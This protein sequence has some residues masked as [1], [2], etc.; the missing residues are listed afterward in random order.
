MSRSLSQ[1]G[2]LRV[3]PESAIYAVNTPSLTP[4]AN[5]QNGQVWLSSRWQ[6]S[7]IPAGAAQHNHIVQP[8]GGWEG[9]WVQEPQVWYNTA[10]SQF[11]MIYTGGVASEYLGLMTCP[12][13]S[14]PM[15]LGN[16]TRSGPN[17]VIGNTYGGWAGSAQHSGV[18]V[19][20]G[21]IY[22]YF[23]DP[24]TGA[25]HVATAATSA[26]SVF[27]HVGIVFTPP[28]GTIAP[29]ANPHVMNV[30]GT[31]TMFFEV[32]DS[33]G[34]RWQLGRATSATPTGTFT[35]VSYPM[36]GLE[37][38][39]GKSCFSNIF[40][41]KEG[42]LYVAWLHC[43][44]GQFQT[45]MYLPSAVYRATS[46][47]LNTWTLTDGQMPLIRLDH[48]FEVDQVADVCLVTGPTGI[49]Y[50]FWSACDNV[51]STGH[52]MGAV[53]APRPMQWDGAKWKPLV[54]ATPAGPNLLIPFH[55]ANQL[56]STLTTTTANGTA[57]AVGIGFG[58][59]TL[60]D[61]SSLTASAALRV[62]TDTAGKVMVKVS[63]LDQ[64]STVKASSSFAVDDMPVNTYR[65]FAPPT[66][67][68]NM[69]SGRTYSVKV[70][71][72][73]YAATA[74]TTV[75]ASDG[76]QLVLTGTPARL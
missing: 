73:N 51:F 5:P 62:K 53:V 69:T 75:E 72:T 36:P 32:R 38:N 1:Q 67:Q 2:S 64:F 58:T 6:D 28:A 3:P 41:V 19:E 52:I 14:D 11:C 31:Y 55:G 13:T 45:T 15:V 70:E 22:V 30:A 34:N 74:T 17:P 25:L 66:I 33:T 49:N 59:V 60:P 27:T 7:Y 46:T 21:T 56:G 54:S 20:N 65:S 43:T 9:A 24:A 47:D 50:A 71:V 63:I 37:I 44:W 57:V 12:G 61:A 29:S 42:P 68:S 23:C 16:W 26:P 76:S 4:P 10:T 39:P 8:A 18:L 40:I 48:Q 35:S